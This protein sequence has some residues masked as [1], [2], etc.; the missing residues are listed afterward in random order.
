MQTLRRRVS[1]DDSA[2]VSARGRPVLLVTLDVPYAEEAIAF[3]VDAAVE[4]GHPLVVVNVAEVLPT[5]YSLLGYGYVERGDLQEALF[6][7]VRLARSLAVQVERLRVCSPHPVD[8]LLE[9]VA[10]R[11]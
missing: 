10:E 9:V 5:A 1:H 2:A 4:N 6:E 8:A 11:E 3:A 7:P